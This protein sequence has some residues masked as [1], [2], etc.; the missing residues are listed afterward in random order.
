MR[1]IVNVSGLSSSESIG[2]TVSQ[3]NRSGDLVILSGAGPLTKWLMICHW[4]GR[5]RGAT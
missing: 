3:N 2:G 4:S 5:N 1:A